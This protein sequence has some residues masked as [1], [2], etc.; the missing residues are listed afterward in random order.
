MKVRSLD[1]LNRSLNDCLSWRKHELKN[2][3]SFFSQKKEPLTA[4]VKASLLLTYAH[5][6][7]GI[8]DTATRYLHHVE[9]QRVLRKDLTSNFLALES[10]SAIK[11]AAMSSQLLLYQQTVEHMRY[12]LEHRYRLPNIGLIDTES[13]LSSRVLK[14]ILACLGLQHAWNS[15]ETKQRLIDVALL[16]TRNDIAHTGQTEDRGDVNLAPVLSDVI[17]LI[18]QFK[19]EVENAAAQKRYLESFG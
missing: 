16:K 2:L 13:N 5:W 3:Q 19:T 4:L 10:I 7:G 11:T 12:N 9:Q 18:E 8:K 14:N 6:E 17:D 15:F 1:E